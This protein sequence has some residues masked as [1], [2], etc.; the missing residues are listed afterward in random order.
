M[1]IL[2]VISNNILWFVVNAWSFLMHTRR[3]LEKNTFLSKSP[4]KYDKL[5]KVI[6]SPSTFELPAKQNNFR[7]YSPMEIGLL[8]RQTFAF[9]KSCLVIQSFCSEIKSSVAIMLILTLRNFCSYC[10][11]SRTNFNVVL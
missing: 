6:F 9:L 1:E 4:S 10:I 3:S 11:S 8:R 5:L 7:V 2:N